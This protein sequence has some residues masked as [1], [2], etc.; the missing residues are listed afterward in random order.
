[1]E[2]IQ[3]INADRGKR[4]VVETQSMEWETSEAD[5]V[6]RKRLERLHGDPEPVT[7]V[8]KY[9]PSSSF[10]PHRHVHG[11]EIF[12][13]E[14][15]FSDNHGDYPAGSYLRNPAGSGH[16][17]FSKEGCTIFVKLQQFQSKDS[18]RINIQTKNKPWL[19]GLVE[20]LTVMP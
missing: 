8:V 9:K 17:P 14:G 12:V 20:G 6:L 18:H 13:L 5:G 19:P 3:E 1:M 11:E 4:V 2:V 7:T 10:P 16:A 15:T